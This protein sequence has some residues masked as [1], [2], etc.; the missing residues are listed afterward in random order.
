MA[1]LLQLQVSGIKLDRSLVEDIEN[2]RCQQIVQAA[3]SLSNGMTIPAVAEGIETPAQH[4]LLQGLGCRVGQGFG[5][6]K[7]DFVEY[8]D[9]W[10]SAYGQS[11]VIKLQDRVRTANT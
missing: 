6:C 9:Q 11:G 4:N 7:P 10:L 2:E 3:L 1:S 8:L 5:L